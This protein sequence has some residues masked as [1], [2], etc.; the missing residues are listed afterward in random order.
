MSLKEKI[1]RFKQKKQKLHEES[2]QQRAEKV[3]KKLEKIKY[4]EPGT[5]SYAMLNRQKPWE[6]SRDVIERR[7]QRRSEK[8]EDSR[9]K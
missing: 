5:I 1:E 2:E 6:L 4:A 9:R 8:L 7:R 3:R